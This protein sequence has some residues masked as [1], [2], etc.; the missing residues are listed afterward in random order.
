MS[1]PSDGPIVAPNA[2]PKEST[3]KGSIENRA[4][5][6]YS[7]AASAEVCELRTQA[8]VAGRCADLGMGG[9]YVD[10]LSPFPVGSV[11]RVRLEHDTREFVCA[12][13]VAYAHASMGMG[14]KFTD[15]TLAHRQVLRYWIAGLS[16][17]ALPEPAAAATVLQ[18]V[19]QEM[20]SNI[21][22]VIGELITLLIG[23]NILTQGEG[24]EMLLQVF[25]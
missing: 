24:A 18:D 22:L 1:V 13:T 2:A 21:R 14:L 20:E 5:T 16:G 23:K 12:A 11:V 8:R 15:M 25:R 7:F 6:R 3:S 17:I 19:S 10:T 4:Q 9:C